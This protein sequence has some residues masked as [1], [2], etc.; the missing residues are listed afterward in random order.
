M[1][2][3]IS[4]Y[5]LL[6]FTLLTLLWT[7]LVCR[8]K[9]SDI[10]AYQKNK[11]TQL[12]SSNP[13]ALSSSTHQ[14]RQGVRKDIWF[15]QEDSSRLHTRIESASSLLTIQPK[16]S[17]FEIVEE[18]QK[19]HCWMQDRLIAEG[20]KPMQQMRYFE[21][22]RGTYL[23]TTQQFLAQ[24]VAISL[25]RL[26]GQTLTF[27]QSRTAPFIRGVAQDVSFSVSG[28]SPQFQAKNFKAQFSK[29][30]GGGI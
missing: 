3:K 29:N 19:I 10:V 22:D 2:R 21:A 7:L 1:F 25:F 8:V 20:G 30:P 11:Q 18:L 13:E 26:P 6:S 4:L 16:G 5:T 28:K 24:N 23:Y 17:S 9:Q 15:T 14:T 12:N 27:D